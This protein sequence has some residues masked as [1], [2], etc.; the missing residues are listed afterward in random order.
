M[1]EDFFQ[2]FSKINGWKIVFEKSVGGFLYAGFSKKQPQKLMCISSQA[3]S[4]IDCNKGICKYCDG[5]YDEDCLIAVCEGIDDEEISIA[6]Q[7]GG[8]LEYNSI[9]GESIIVNTSKD[10]ITEV[11]FKLNTGKII[12]ISKV[13]GY[14]TAGFSYDGN[15]F[16]FCDDGGITVLKKV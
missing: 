5:D 11:T 3:I 7:Y 14:Y 6:G 15:F 1:Y 4:F 13:Y 2:E 8:R 16:V 12:K 9:Q 10:F